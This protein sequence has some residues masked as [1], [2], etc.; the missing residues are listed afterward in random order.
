M[1]YDIYCELCSQSGLTPSGAAKQ[2]GFN[3]ASITMWKNTGNPPKPELLNKIAD[4]FHVSTDYLLGKTDQKEE[5]SVREDD[6][7]AERFMAAFSRLTSEQ[8]ELVFGVMEGFLH[9]KVEPP[10]EK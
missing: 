5:P 10:Q 9:G 4:Y 1:F 2:I 8:Q 6:E 7:L 3:R